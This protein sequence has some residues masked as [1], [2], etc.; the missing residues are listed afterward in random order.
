MRKKPE[1]EPRSLF[2]RHL[3]AEDRAVER[4][5]T[6][7]VA[8]RNVHPDELIVH[9]GLLHRSTLTMALPMPTS[10]EPEINPAAMDS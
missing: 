3:P 2:L 10:A 9:R 8:H 4:H 7:E 1:D 6:F 5:G